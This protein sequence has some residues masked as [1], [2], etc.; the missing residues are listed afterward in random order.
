MSRCLRDRDQRRLDWVLHC[1]AGWWI[2]PPK[3]NIDG[4]GEAS[5]R[6]KRRGDHVARRRAFR[7]TYPARFDLQL[8]AQ[9]RLQTEGAHIDTVFFI[10]EGRL[11][12]FVG[13]D[14]RQE[15]RVDT[16]VPGDCF[17]LAALDGGR[18]VVSVKTI[19][20]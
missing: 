16:L 1:H 20:P 3:K 5:S 4:K 11:K 19:T 10:L 18:C 15:V 9:Y 7:P 17:G 2:L 8:S 12:A 14:S 13:K 6:D